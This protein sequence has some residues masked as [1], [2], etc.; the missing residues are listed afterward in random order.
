MGNDMIIRLF[1]LSL[2]IAI[3]P[4]WTFADY[5]IQLGTGTTGLVGIAAPTPIRVGQSFTTIG[6]GTVGTVDVY[7]DDEGTAP[8]DNLLLDIYATD[9]SGFPTGAIMGQASISNDVGT[10]CNKKVFTFSTPPSLSATTKYALVWSRSGAASG[11]NYS[12]VCGT[13][14]DEYA[15][16]TFMRDDIGVWANL[17]Q[18][19]NATI[20]ITTGASGVGVAGNFF[21][22]GEW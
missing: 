1:S 19:A 12:V 9:G 7:L 5:T 22:W 16:G 2:I 21:V 20:F 18:E 8:T 4:L 13:N 14:S 10:A 3:F 17:T 11:L 6:A 15:D